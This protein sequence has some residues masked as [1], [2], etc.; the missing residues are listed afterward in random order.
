MLNKKKIKNILNNDPWLHLAILLITLPASSMLRHIS[1]TIF[2]WR[3]A[4]FPLFRLH[5]TQLK[6]SK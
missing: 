3:I 1:A 5:H 4:P 2:Q 6:P